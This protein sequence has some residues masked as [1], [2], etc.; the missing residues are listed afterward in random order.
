MNEDKL[1][2]ILDIDGTL[3]ISLFKNLGKDDKANTKD[4]IASLAFIEPFAL[5]KSEIAPLAAKADHVLVVTGRQS[6][7]ATVTKRWLNKV[8]KINDYTLKFL[9]YLTYDA[10]I[11]N[12]KAALRKAIIEFDDLG[13][14]IVMYEDDENITKWTKINFDY[15]AI[16]LVKD[17]ISSKV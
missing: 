6:E 17:G 2:L 5:V 12:K 14:S 10:Y 13:C 8:L 15:V 4:F 3:A 11:D 1:A 16:N 7:M 9:N